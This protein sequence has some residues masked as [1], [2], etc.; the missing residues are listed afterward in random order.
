M[1][2]LL[3]P[4]LA[5]GVV[6]MM[7]HHGGR[8][9]AKRPAAL[10]ESPAHIDIIASD[11]VAG[12]EAADRL[13][14]AFAKGHIAAR[15]VLG[16]SVAKE[17]VHR[18]ARCV[19]HAVGNPV[20]IVGREMGTSH[21]DMVGADKDGRQMRQPLRVWVDIVID[22]GHDLATSCLHT[23][24]ASVTASAMFSADEP[25]AIALND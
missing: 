24:I 5:N 3:V 9:K 13:Q 25:E 17:H 19:G 14:G 6:S 8:M 11:A 1:P 20:A 18:S 15:H 22:V 21:P 4:V 16:T 10:L 23:C 7:P 2:F 12:V